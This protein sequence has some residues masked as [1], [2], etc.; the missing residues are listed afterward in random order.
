[1]I[2]VSRSASARLSRKECEVHTLDLAQPTLGRGAFPPLL[3]IG[4]QFVETGQHFG[5][6][7]YPRISLI[8]R[9]FGARYHRGR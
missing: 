7:R 8:M 2:R 4:L 9:R 6:R 3:Q 1:V 5:E